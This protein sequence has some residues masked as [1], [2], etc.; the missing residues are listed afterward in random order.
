MV[1]TRPNIIFATALAARFSKNS[2]HKHTKAVKTI[3]KYLKS[4]RKQR[5][6]YG[7][8]SKKALKIQNSFNSDW[9]N[10]KK[11]QISTFGYIFIF[12]GGLIS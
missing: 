1:E 9:G 3:F 4:S 10:N 5:I 12:N 11:S 2:F 7:K 6:I 8:T